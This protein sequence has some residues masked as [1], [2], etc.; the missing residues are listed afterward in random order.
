VEI[1]NSSVG[2]EEISETR[3]NDEAGAGANKDSHRAGDRAS[4]AAGNE[5]SDCASDHSPKGAA[6]KT[7]N[8]RTASIGPRDQIDLI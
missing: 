2:D 7:A 4:F 6:A 8:D 1:I 3:A 5:S